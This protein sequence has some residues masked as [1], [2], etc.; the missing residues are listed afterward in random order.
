MLKPKRWLETL[1]VFLTS[2]GAIEN[3]QDNKMVHQVN[4]EGNQ[5]IRWCIQVKA[6]GNLRYSMWWRVWSS[7]VLPY[8]MC[9]SDHVHGYKIMFKCWMYKS[10]HLHGYKS[11][12]TDINAWLNRSREC[13]CVTWIYVIIIMCKLPNASA[14][15]QNQ[16]HCCYAMCIM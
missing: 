12:Y 4:S 5:K 2:S 9:Q 16:T 13:T 14:W 10:D 7:L 1:K 6:E 11:M 15:V 3:I 8:H